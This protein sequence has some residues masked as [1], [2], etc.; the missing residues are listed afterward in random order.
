MIQARVGARGALRPGSRGGT[1]E[2]GDV[3]DAREL[4]LDLAAA[5]AEHAAIGQDGCGHPLALRGHGL[6]GGHDRLHAVDVDDQR[7]TRGA[8]HLQ[9][10]VLAGTSRRWKSSCVA[11]GNCPAVVSKPVPAGET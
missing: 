3:T 4:I 5:G 8:A 10:A 11:P 2:L 1:P 6:R 7:G 9:D